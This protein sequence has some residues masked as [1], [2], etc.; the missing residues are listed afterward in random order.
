MILAAVVLLVGYAL[1]LVA[2]HRADR[3]FMGYE[4][5]E[6]AGRLSPGP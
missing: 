5:E 2:V 1:A 6:R 3:R 4:R